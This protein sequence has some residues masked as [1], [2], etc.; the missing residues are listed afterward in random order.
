MIQDTATPPRWRDWTAKELGK[1]LGV[2]D[3]YIRRL[4]LAGKI[5]AGKRGPAWI[6]SDVEA[7]RV[8]EE[9]GV[10]LP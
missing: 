5:K 8:A 9:R 6:I 10:K 2:S 1:A 3:A 7:R 4:I